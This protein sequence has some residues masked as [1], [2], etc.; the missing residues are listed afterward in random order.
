MAWIIQRRNGIWYRG[1][2]V[3]TGRRVKDTL[4][5]IYKDCYVSLRT[6]DEAEARRLF[7][8]GG[9]PPPEHTQSEPVAPLT[10]KIEAFL[11]YL[12]SINLDPK[13]VY[14][15][16]NMFVH[17]LKYINSMEDLRPQKESISPNLNRF[18]EYTRK[19]PASTQGIWLR[20]LRTF[21]AWAGVLHPKKHNADSDLL[22]QI[23]VE[24]EEVFR[25]RKLTDKEKS[26]LFSM[27][28]SPQMTEFLH[29]LY[30]SGLRLG[31]ALFL[32]WGQV[33]QDSNSIHVYKQK[34][35][36]E[37]FIPMLDQGMKWVGERPAAA[38]DTDR[39]FIRWSDAA[40]FYVSWRS[41]LRRARKAG[42]KGEVRPHDLR[43]TRASDLVEKHGFNAFDLLKF[44]GWS[45]LKLAERYVHTHTEDLR[46]KLLL[47]LS[48]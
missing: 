1:E 8:A 20:N 9:V 22:R 16:R 33:R 21:L 36:K 41:T 43:H 3:E 5:P 13:T 28:N 11:A 17:L 38:K 48:K 23:L 4:K 6:K 27:G 31:Q 24:D 12:R 19:R 42:F 26:L 39:V 34:R 32:T 2:R 14:L 37:R 30:E 40:A 29:F 45:D 10:S 7:K 15:Y 25:G 46:T 35:Q 44:F 18:M 47:P